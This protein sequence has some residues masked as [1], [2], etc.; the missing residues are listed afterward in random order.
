MNRSSAK[1]QFLEQ[2]S[3]LG[4]PGKQITSWAGSWAARMRT[5]MRMITLTLMKMR[6]L[7]PMSTTLTLS[8]TLYMMLWF[9]IW[10]AMSTLESPVVGRAGGSRLSA[11]CLQLPSP[12]CLGTSAPSS[13][14]AARPAAASSSSGSF[15]H[16]L[17][18]SCSP[19]LAIWFACSLWMGGEEHLSFFAHSAFVA[20]TRAV[21]FHSHRGRRQVPS[22]VLGGCRGLL[23]QELG[24]A[25]GEAP[26][27]RA[28][29]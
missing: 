21:Q 15:A 29:L 1:N 3:C 27:A 7:E 11:P 16:L 25:K 23:S 18:L 9:Q 24:N 12:C 10:I 22:T 20:V 28:L 2:H 6:T 19:S 8:L 4:L 14:G 13:A 17:M 26:P 5:L